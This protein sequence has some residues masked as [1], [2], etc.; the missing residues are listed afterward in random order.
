MGRKEKVYN[1]LKELCANIT[2]EHLNK[3]FSGFAA[4]DIGE[5]IRVSRS[6]VSKELNRLLEEKKVIK[7]KG[8]PVYYLDKTKIENILARTIEEGSLELNSINALLKPE[9]ETTTTTSNKLEDTFYSL[10]GSQGSLEVAIKQAKAAVLYPPRGLHTLIIGPTGVG[11][12]MFAEKMYQ[13]ALQTG[14]ISANAQLV[15]FNCAEYADNPQLLLSYL[16]GYVKGAFTGAVK[17]KKGIIEKAKEGILLLDEIHRLSPE[18]QEMLF[19]LMDKNIYRRLGETE[20]IREANVLLIGATTEDINSTL[21]KTFL[22]RI[23]MIIKIPQLRERSLQERLQLIKEFFRGEVKNVKV[24]I[25][26]YKDVMKAFLLYDC[27]GNIGQLKADIQLTCARGF[28][29]YKKGNKKIVE[30]DTPLLTEYVYKGLFNYKKYRDEILNLPDVNKQKYYEFTEAQKEEQLISIVDDYN[31][32]ER[33]YQEI[34]EEYLVYSQLGYSQVKISEILNK[35]IEKYL[36]KLLKKCISK[37]E[38]PD[39]EELF[40]I[41]SPRVYFSVETALKVAERKLKKKFS[42]KIYI[43]FSLHISALMERLINNR[44]VTDI[45]INKI[46]LNNPREFAVAKLIRQIL[47]KD[48]EIAIPQEELGFIAMFLYAVD[49]EERCKHN[50]IGIIVLAHGERTAS[51]IADVVNNLLGTKDCKAIDMPLEVKVE[52][53]LE[54]TIEEVK[55]LDQGK[56]VLLLVDMGSLVAFGE[57]ITKKTKVKTMS[58][59]MVSTPIVLE[60]VRKC[61]LPEMTL[62]QLVQDLQGANPYLGRLAT[63]RVKKQVSISKPKTIITTCLTGEGSALKLAE[64]LRKALPDLNEYGVRLE[65][66]NEKSFLDANIN[67]KGDILA[68]VGSVDLNIPQVPYISVDEVIIG[69]GIKRIENLIYGEQYHGTNNSKDQGTLLDLLKD[70]LIFLNPDK[71]YNTVNKSFHYINNKIKV[72]NYRGKEIRF[73]LHCCCMVERL[74]QGEELPYEQITEVIKGNIEMYKIIKESLEIVEETFGIE[75]PDTEIGYII[76]LFD[77]L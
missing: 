65:P 21:L 39:K 18:G 60:A 13:Y 45:D 31:I 26:V 76:D 2:L 10:I 56:G 23:P 28:L 41:V 58:L 17:D 59:G 53:I 38:M 42:K 63:N 75:I 55:E 62:E 66:V 33:L 40:K 5:K 35:Y 73:I 61:L 36:E 22:R 77:T 68:V 46:A 44:S 47:E 29:E 20:E 25:R 19:L 43:A 30:I 70:A 6:N 32:S 34:S 11:K 57:I 12:T 50:K 4:M 74:I 52:N 69:E 15:I 14:T 49:T 54:I 48:L 24:P 1:A 67:I 51:S 16:F 37:K 8:R 71:A 64:L 3:G 7:L 27:Q 72:E 9:T